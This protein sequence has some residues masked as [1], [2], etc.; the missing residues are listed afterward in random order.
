MM[1]AGPVYL[2]PLASIAGFGGV[3]GFLFYPLFS[4]EN[5]FQLRDY[6]LFA[7]LCVKVR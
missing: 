1:S 3:R 7:K 5:A 4:F 6:S 2:K